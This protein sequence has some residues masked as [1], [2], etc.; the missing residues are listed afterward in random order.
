MTNIGDGWTFMIAL[1]LHV[2]GS[3]LTK[4]SGLTE[5]RSSGRTEGDEVKRL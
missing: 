5:V 1:P 4:G 2:D 3:A